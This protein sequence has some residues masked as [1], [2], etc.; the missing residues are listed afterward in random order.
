MDRVLA[1]PDERIGLARRALLD[2][3]ATEV[4]PA[5]VT[6]REPVLLLEGAVELRQGDDA[7]VGRVE[8]V[9]RAF[10]TRRRRRHQPV[11]RF[12][13]EHVVARGGRLPVVDLEIEDA[14]D[15]TGVD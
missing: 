11:A 8:G 7:L 2:V 1:D 9:D 13:P 12:T 14:L 6:T 4:L 15:L 3:P 10:A 5:G